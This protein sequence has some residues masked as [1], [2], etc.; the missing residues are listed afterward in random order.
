MSLAVSG[1]IRPAPL[2]SWAIMNLAPS[3][4]DIDREPAGGTETNSNGLAS[5]E[6]LE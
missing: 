2:F 3:V 5:P 1:F 4:P 6:A